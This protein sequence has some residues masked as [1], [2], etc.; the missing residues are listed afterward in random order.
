MKL[1][2]I[3]SV[4]A[5]VGLLVVGTA[6]AATDQDSFFGRWNRRDIENE[7]YGYGYYHM[8]DL[9]DLTEEELEEYRSQR[10]LDGETMIE[11]LKDEGLFEEWKENMLEN[12]SFRLDY[13]VEN[14]ILTQEEA[15]ELLEGFEDRIEE[16][17]PFSF[18]NI[19]GRG[20]SGF[21]RGFRGFCGR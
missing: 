13:Q 9:T 21:N 18:G 2:K 1:T 20:P 17:P 8:Q 12:F 11:Y 16:G 6:F 19:R 15:D 5:V 3:V 7:D 4:I 14:D 10:Y